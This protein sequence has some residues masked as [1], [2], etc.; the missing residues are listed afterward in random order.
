MY[1]YWNETGFK[2]TAYE[3]ELDRKLANILE[4]LLNLE[5]RMASVEKE[6]VVHGEKKMG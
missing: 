4:R 6:L 3:A 1:D 2:Q 5:R